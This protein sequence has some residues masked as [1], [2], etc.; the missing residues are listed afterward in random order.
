[1]SYYRELVDLSPDGTAEYAHFDCDGNLE[2]LEWTDDATSIIENNKVLSNDGSRGYGETREW[3]HIASVP[4]SLVR[5]WEVEM[6]V[7]ID[8]LL[9][10]E[11]FKDLLKKIK[12]PDYSLLRVDK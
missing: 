3:R 4:R 6:G 7:P 12:D 11:G 2:G 9:S 8:F 5:K 1:M 10:K